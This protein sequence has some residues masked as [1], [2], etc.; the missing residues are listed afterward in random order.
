MPVALAILASS[1]LASCGDDEYRRPRAEPGKVVTVLDGDTP[2]VPARSRLTDIAM[3]DDGVLFVAFWVPGVEPRDPRRGL[4]LGLPEEGEP[5]VVA[6]DEENSFPEPVQFEPNALTVDP[7]SG[8]LYVVDVESQRIRAVDRDGR[9]RNVMEFGGRMKGP[10]DTF[11][12]QPAHLTMDAHSGDL[13]MADGC[14]VARIHGDEATVVFGKDGDGCLDGTPNTDSLSVDPGV[15][16]L[17]VGT[18]SIGGLAV[19]P[20][21]GL[22]VVATNRGVYR[23]EPDGAL[24]LLAG[25]GPAAA[26]PYREGGVN[27]PR[28]VDIDFATGPYLEDGGGLAFGGEDGTL[29]LG[30]PL[31]GLVLRIPA[32]QDLLEKLASVKG[33][34]RLV[35]GGDGDLFVALSHQSER[36]EP[37]VRVIALPGS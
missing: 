21:T 29:Y 30:A 1:T 6:D 34:R 37:V 13:Y 3:R 28:E 27:R 2:G 25:E 33:P 16:A 19:D 9:R 18:P 26:G 36:D 32:G 35:L 15:P 23:I 20:K 14:Q 22:V 24:L 10:P 8:T 5:F 11:L 7:A 12:R 31:D 17:E 4:I